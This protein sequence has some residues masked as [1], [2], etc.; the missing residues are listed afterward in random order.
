MNRFDCEK[1]IEDNKQLH[2]SMNLKH[3]PM[4]SKMI[5]DILQMTKIQHRATIECKGKDFKKFMH[6]QI[7]FNQTL[8]LKT[9]QEN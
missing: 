3:A 2:L 7:P 5:D 8:T 1:A 4:Y 6:K 9:H